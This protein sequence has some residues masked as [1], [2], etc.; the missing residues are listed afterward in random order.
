VEASIRQTIG[1]AYHA[2][3]LYPRVQRQ[4]ERALD[5]RLRVLGE[6]HPNTP[7]AISDWPSC[8]M[9]KGN[10]RSWSNC[11]PGFW[12]CGVA[13]WARS[14]APRSPA[15]MTLRGSMS[16]KA[17]MRRRSRSTPRHYSSDDVST[18]NS[19]PDTLGTMNNLALL[20]RK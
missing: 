20:Y 16:I 14:M 2:L 7:D 4:M 19:T 11:I 18:Q 17:N 15:W 13:Y 10:T 3:V 5:L 1:K 12:T 8:T 9:R 6:D